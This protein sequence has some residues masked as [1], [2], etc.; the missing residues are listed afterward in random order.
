MISRA[1]KLNR[2]SL[3]RNY[4][5]AATPFRTHFGGEATPTTST[6]YDKASS[7][8]TYVLHCKD[9]RKAAVI[10]PVLDFDI[11]SGKVTTESADALLAFLHENQLSVEH[12]LETHAHAD[13]LTSAKY[14]QKHLHAPISIGQRIREVQATFGPRY[15]LKPDS[16]VGSFDRLLQDDEIVSLGKLKGKVMHLPGHTPDHVGYVFGKSV[17]TGDSVFLAPVFTARADFPGG[18]ASSLATSIEKLL[19]LPHDYK[20]FVGHDYPGAEREQSCW[21]TVGDQLTLNDH[22]KQEDFAKF[23]E[24][25]DKT[26]NTPKLL[27]PAIQVN[28]RGGRL[29]PSDEDGI[30][31]L[32]LPITTNV[33]L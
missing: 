22:L 19:S 29:P 25:R 31:R 30:S 33:D 27:H 18:V 24:E 11:S 2:C 28:I 12:I 5:A 3:V 26:L 7:T 9:T 17:Y 32:K 8:W 10:D 21:T 15:G 23:R 6:F 14:L 20:L 4:G 1:F 13:H 16:F